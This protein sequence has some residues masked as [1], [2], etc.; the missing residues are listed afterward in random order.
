[1]RVPALFLIPLC[2][3]AAAAAE[4]LR[5]PSQRPNILLLMAEDLSPRVGAYGD[6]VAVTPALDRLA[7][8]GLRFTNAFT[9]AGVCAP[10][11][12]AQI[13]GVHQMALGAQ[14]M[15]S[16]DG[17]YLAVPPP[18]VKAYPEL[19]RRAGY[20]TFTDHKLDYQ[21]S[22]VFPDSG[23]FTIWDAEGRG[24][25]WSGR[26]EGQPFFGL[27]NFQVTHES[28]I[29]P[30][31]AWPKSAAHLLFQALYLFSF[32]GHRDVVKPEEVR[33]PPYY[34]DTPTVRADLARHY[35]NVHLMD[36]QVGEIRSRLEAEGLA[37]STILVWT[38]DHGDGLPRAKRELYDSG[39]RVPL[40]VYWPEA[41]QPDGAE[42]GGV[43]EQLVSFVDLAPSLL[44]LAGLEP[45]AF[46]VGR[47]LLGSGAG[48]KPRRYVFAAK[49]RMDDIPD[50]QRAV[51]DR[52]FKYI[53]NYRAGEPGARR[54]A[55]RE[56]LDIM[57][58]LW[59]WREAG[60]LQ[61]AA[62]RWFEPRPPEELYDTLADPHEVQN[63]AEDPEHR[64][65]LARLRAALDAWLERTPD[66]GAIPEEEL[67]Q[68]FWPGGEQP[69]TAN[70]SIAVEPA[71]E[72]RAR[73]ILACE[74]EG[75]SLGYRIHGAGTR[76]VEGWRLYGG[77]FEAALGAAIEVKA[78]RY[79]YAESDVV[80]SELR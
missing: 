32:W 79:G 29:F 45:P 15:R 80:R 43:D 35:N 25:D 49:D 21:F 42:P 52:R 67:R 34:P 47:P 37:G 14:H 6:P 50:R 5:A 28:A 65:T 40:V 66:L 31:P 57:R 44:R 41:L 16:S 20:Y 69:V 54:L 77:P 26:E 4:A 48:S 64:A 73:L 12:A 1:M 58:E 70:P 72:G 74:T 33:V 56:N 78:V 30:R 24:S 3:C 10:S 9:T 27:I 39:I 62:A 55:F 8:E 22:G 17:G 23:P 60:R 19:L 2:C 61:P 51:R 75:A 36:Q 18:E 7:Q 76:R 11:R 53:R 13:T 59:E 38:T 63:L 71:G 68:R 46:M